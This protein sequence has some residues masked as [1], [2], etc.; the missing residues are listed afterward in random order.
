M[1]ITEIALERLRLPLDPPF[2]AAWDEPRGTFEGDERVVL[3]EA[4][5]K[6]PHWPALLPYDTYDAVLTAT[7]LHWLRTDALDGLYGRLAGL[8]AAVVALLLRAPFLVVLLVAAAVA[9]GLRAL[10]W[11]A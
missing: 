6:D 7:A 8:A 11:A 10:G 4:D 2:H 5:L 9:A 1:K 3:V